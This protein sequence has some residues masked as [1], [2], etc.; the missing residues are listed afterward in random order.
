MKRHAFL[1][2][3]TLFTQT[4][5]RSEEITIGAL[6]FPGDPFDQYMQRFAEN[7]SAQNVPDLDIK[8]LIRGEVGPEEILMRSV[9]RGRV[10]IA[11]FT[12]SGIT[13]VL[14]EFDVLRTPYLFSSFDEV[15]FVLDNHIAP[16]M[17]ERLAEQ[18]LHFLGFSDEGWF[19]LY[20]QTAFPMPKT[21]REV[22]M[23]ALQSPAS[24]AFIQ[25]IGADTIQIPFADV[26]TGLQT[27]LISGGETGTMIYAAASLY[28]EAP[29]LTLTRHA[30]S[31]G[32]MVAHKPWFDELPLSVRSTI[33]D[34]VPPVSFIRTI[35]R[36]W[37]K[38]QLDDMQ[39]NGIQVHTLS[40]EQKAKWRDVSTSRIDALIA[41][42]DGQAQAFFRSVMLAKQAY[43]AQIS[44]P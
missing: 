9:R 37:I 31:A 30:Y 23:R 38:N 19:N 43:S 20:G 6:T 1:I 28:D 14:P 4:T 16:L 25:S 22:R 32:V 10:Q 42:T 24:Q 11:S 8:M 13:A 44:S 15:D 18:D 39:K 41:N 26:L 21:A 36:A 12:A 40:P 29:H 34:A 35:L 17:S 3:L 2:A 33:A 5:V 7:L 27:G